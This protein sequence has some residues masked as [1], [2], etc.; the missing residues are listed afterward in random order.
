MAAFFAEVCNRED[1][2]FVL[3]ISCF[4]FAKYKLRGAQG[5]GGG[6]V[7]KTHSLIQTRNNCTQLI[8]IVQVNLHLFPSYFL[9]N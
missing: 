5:S 1:L 7:I 8:S 6:I 3:E 9:V 2:Y 4:Y